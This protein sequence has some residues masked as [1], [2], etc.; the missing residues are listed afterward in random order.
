[1]ARE[2][3]FTSLGVGEDCQRTVV[4]EVARGLGDSVTGS[5]ETVRETRWGAKRRKGRNPLGPEGRENLSGVRRPG[6]VLAWP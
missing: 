4:N 6:L 2:C 3:L 1:M 5:R